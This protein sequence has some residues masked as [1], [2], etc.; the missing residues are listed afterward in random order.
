[1]PSQALL[2]QVQ[3]RVVASAATTVVLVEGLSDRVAVE[4][5]AARLGCPLDGRGVAVLPTGGAT[6]VGRFLAMLGPQGRDVRLAGLCDAAEAGWLR[7]RLDRAGVGTQGFFVC[8]RDLEDELIRA[9]GT[10]A[11]LAIV[12]REGERES[13]RRLRQM[14]YHR[15]G[16]LDAHLHRFI[17]VR[18]GRKERYARLLAEAVDADSMPAPLRDLVA[19]VCQDA[20]T[21]R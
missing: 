3:A 1:M 4:T 14:P 12:D 11:V 17:G 2:A 18:S 9:A 19:Y 8:D 6:N 13:L 15:G 5:V 16:S 7:T 20:P 10:D 21:A